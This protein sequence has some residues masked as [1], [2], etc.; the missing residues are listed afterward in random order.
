[1][2]G[3]SRKVAR[4]RFLFGA[5]LES[6]VLRSKGDLKYSDVIWDDSS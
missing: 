6:E 1:L 4:G 5:E 3:S 2:A